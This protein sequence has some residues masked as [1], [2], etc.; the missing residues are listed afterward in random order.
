M[1]RFSPDPE[2]ENPSAPSTTPP[3]G[4][5]AGQGDA[6]PFADVSVTKTVSPRVARAGGTLHYTVVVRNAGPGT[7]YDVVASEVDP[8]S[9]AALDLHTTKGECRG[10]RPARCAVGTLRRGERATITV[11]VPATRLGRTRN[12]VAVTSSTSDPNLRNNRDS[13][14]ALVLPALSPRFTG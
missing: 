8:R 7:A 11:D 14:L 12:H 10:T 6:G 1:N 13:A 2:P 5:V 4:V 9:D 3:D